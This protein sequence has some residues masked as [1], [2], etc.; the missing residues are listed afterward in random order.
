MKLFLFLTVLLWSG[1]ATAQTATV[2]DTA[3]VNMRSGKAENYRIIRVLPPR[4]ELEVIETDQ[5]YAKVRT[6]DGETGWVLRKFLDIHKAEKEKTNQNQAV[7][8]AAQKELVAARVEMANLQREL[9]K[10]QQQGPDG[11]ASSFQLLLL[12]ALGAFAAGMATGILI[13]KA[14]YHKRLHGLRI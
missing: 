5:E 9:E 14:Y 13:L 4:A 3:N 6:A 11:T 1:V 2:A 10:K 7:L 8:E 12:V